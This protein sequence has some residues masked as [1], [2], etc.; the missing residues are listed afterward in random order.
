MRTAFGSAT[1]VLQARS[2]D[3]CWGVRMSASG[4]KC[5]AP[6]ARAPR[7]IWRYSPPENFEKMDNLRPH[8]VR[9]ED[10]LLGNKPYKG[11][12]SNDNNSGTFLVL[13]TEPCK[14]NLQFI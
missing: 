4:A 8:F 6:Q 13:E 7:G 12:G 2:Q 3:F 10:S 11:E 5:G 9:F 1:V 14:H